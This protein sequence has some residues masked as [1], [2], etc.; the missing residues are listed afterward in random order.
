M[1]VKDQEGIK[2]ILKNNH[3]VAIVGYSTN[4]EKGAHYVPKFLKEHGY[5]IVPVNPAVTE[6]LGEKAYASLKDIPFPVDV[7]D[8][9]RRPDAMPEIA[10]EAVAI[11]AKV[12][13]MQKGIENEEAAKIGQ[14]CRPKGR[15][16]PLHAGTVHRAVPEINPFSPVLP[17]LR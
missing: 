6:G 14:R 10:R 1:I 7:V 3:V 12:L 16:R 17:S 13:W 2:E 8:C 5:Q 9:F 4:E 11:G 15:F